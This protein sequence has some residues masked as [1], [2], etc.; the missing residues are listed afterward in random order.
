MAYYPLFFDL[1]DQL[2]TIIGGGHV[3]YEKAVRLA[4]F[5]PKLRVIA[6][7]VLASIEEIPNIEIIQR[8]WQP[9]DLDG[10]FLII[11]ATNDRSENAKIAGLCKEKRILCNAVDDARNSQ[12]IFGAV[13]SQEDL[14]IGISTSGASP[15]AAV[16]LKEKIAEELPKNMSE[17]LAWL[18]ACRPEIIASVSANRRPALFRALFEACMQKKRPLSAAEYRKIVSSYGL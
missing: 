12:A 13:V 11:A 3:A 7:D 2:I 8:D 16:Y 1:S 18:A 5:D 10:S 17:I 4:G 6:P 14:C 9:G 15:S